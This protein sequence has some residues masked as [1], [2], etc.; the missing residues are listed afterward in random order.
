ME[1]VTKSVASLTL[2]DDELDDR[3]IDIAD[4]PIDGQKQKIRLRLIPEEIE[5][6]KTNPELIKS[7]LQSA[8]CYPFL[9]YPKR[10][11]LILDRYHGA[12]FINSI[13]TPTLPACVIR[14]SHSEPHFIVFSSHSNKGPCSDNYITGEGNHI[15]HH[16][17]EAVDDF[18]WHD[19]WLIHL[20]DNEP[21]LPMIKYDRCRKLFNEVPQIST[22]STRE[23]YIQVFHETEETRKR[24]AEARAVAGKINYLNIMQS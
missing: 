15:I 20:E 21:A 10:Y 8:A 17:L 5:T 12:H 24:R 14:A 2:D 18:K 4:F 7:F 19:A 6:L 16:W 13:K 9:V 11:L 1:E 22:P 23:G 3:Y